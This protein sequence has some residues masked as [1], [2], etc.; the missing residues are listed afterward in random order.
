MFF[1]MCQKVAGS[2]D[3]EGE[4]AGAE[5]C[6]PAGH[7]DADS[8]AGSSSDLAGMPAH[9]V[10]ASMPGHDHAAPEPRGPPCVVI[11]GVGSITYYADRGDFQTTCFCR[12]H[13]GH[14]AKTRTARPRATKPQ[15]GRPLGYLVAW[16]LE[17]E[18]HPTTRAHVDWDPRH[19]VGPTRE[20]RLVARA[21]ARA[22]YPDFSTLEECERPPRDGEEEE[23]EECP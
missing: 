2:S 18:Q 20:A 16:L 9:G 6:A 13:V 4:D 8:G 12:G 11:P 21:L 15:Q 17:S 7:V 5:H 3:S 22:Q 1:G 23:P 14:C 10:G 19:G